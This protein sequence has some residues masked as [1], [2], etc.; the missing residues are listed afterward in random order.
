MLL[1]VDEIVWVVGQKKF[2]DFSKLVI[3][4]I[5]RKNSFESASGPYTTLNIAQNG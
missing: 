4:N 2:A 5:N 1:N 3:P